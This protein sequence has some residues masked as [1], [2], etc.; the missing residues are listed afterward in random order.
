MM[1][2]LPAEFIAIY[3]FP[4]FATFYF[5]VFFILTFLIISMFFR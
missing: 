4:R 5:Q 3:I 1:Y 2:R